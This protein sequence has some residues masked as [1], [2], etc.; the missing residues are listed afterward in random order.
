MRCR[1]WNWSMQMKIPVRTL[2]H[3]LILWLLQQC[4]LPARVVNRVV[5]QTRAGKMRSKGQCSQKKGLY[6]LHRGGDFFLGEFASFLCI[7]TRCSLFFIASPNIAGSPST[8]PFHLITLVSHMENG[9]N[10]D[11]LLS[12][13][14]FVGFFCLKI[15][16]WDYVSIALWGY[17]S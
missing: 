10:K 6:Q 16:Y 3:S 13:G 2:Q 1:G 8:L 5:G 9:G 14:Q 15:I 17:W 12:H 11:K 7:F 4:V